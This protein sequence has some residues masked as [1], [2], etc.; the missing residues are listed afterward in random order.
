MD[1]VDLAHSQDVSQQLSVDCRPESTSKESEERGNIGQYEHQQR[2]P[3]T[4]PGLVI[5]YLRSIDEKSNFSGFE[6][7][8]SP[9]GST[10]CF[11][12]SAGQVSL[13]SDA[14]TRTG[15]VVREDLL[16]RKVAEL[17]SRASQAF[18]AREEEEQKYRLVGTSADPQVQKAAKHRALLLEHRKCLEKQIEAKEERRKA[19]MDEDRASYLS[20][21][22]SQ[23]VSPPK[24]LALCLHK[25][26]IA[27]TEDTDSC[28][29]ALAEQLAKQKRS[30]N[31]DPRPAAIL[32]W[33]KACSELK[34]QLDEQLETKKSQRQALKVSEL[35]L[36]VSLLQAESQSRDYRE[37]QDR[38]MRRHEHRK[39]YS[40]WREGVQIRDIRKSIEATEM[41]KRVPAFQACSRLPEADI[42]EIGPSTAG[43]QY[44]MT[45]LTSRPGTALAPFTSGIDG[46][47]TPLSARPQSVSGVRHSLM[48]SFEQ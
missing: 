2:R 5:P 41:G 20:L 22:S 16:T 40:A 6:V 9:R 42:L 38:A 33:N 18:R 3:A 12:D 45:P 29:N 27:T 24:A 39:L 11:L 8:E 46:V 44:P 10:L 7:P 1:E 19:E 36:E 13:G 21:E 47:A 35:E 32:G 28:A 17:E 30:G 4:T 14:S 15:Q 43:M 23:A 25:R 34:G 37:I 48:P 26:N 31:H